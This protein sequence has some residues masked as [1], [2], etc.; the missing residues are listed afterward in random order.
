[1]NADELSYPQISQ[2]DADSEKQLLNRQDAKSAKETK[3]L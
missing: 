3:N 2:I 1:M